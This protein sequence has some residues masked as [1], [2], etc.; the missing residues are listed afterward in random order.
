MIPGDLSLISA[1]EALIFCCSVLLYIS[2]LTE[3]VALQDIDHIVLRILI[4]MI[5]SRKFYEMPEIQEI[6]RLP[7]HGA[8]IPFADVEQALE[9]KYENSPFYR[10]LNGKWQFSLYRRHLNDNSQSQTYDIV[11]YNKTSNDR[12][13]DDRAWS[14]HLRA[15]LRIIYKCIKG[16]ARRN[17]II[18]CDNRAY[19]SHH[20]Q[21]IDL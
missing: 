21:R 2:E 6:N 10:S 14:G 19:V 5:V 7:M 18:A 16:F 9:R 13:V 3:S 20:I 11:R 1:K 15:S 4:F 12:T 8:E 17:H